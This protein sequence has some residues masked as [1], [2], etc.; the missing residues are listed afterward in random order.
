MAGM[1]TSLVMSAARVAISALFIS[2]TAM[3]DDRVAS[4]RQTCALDSQMSEPSPRVG[5]ARRRPQADQ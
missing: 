1:R 4:A 3:E 2:A 5:R